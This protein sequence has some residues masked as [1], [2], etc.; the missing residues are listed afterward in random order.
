MEG[1]LKC[2]KLNSMSYRETSLV[3]KFRRWLMLLATSNHLFVYDRDYQQLDKIRLGHVLGMGQSANRTE[4]MMFAE[5]QVSCY[6]CTMLGLNLTD[7]HDVKFNSNNPE[8][9]II[10]VIQ[11]GARSDRYMV[12]LTER[13]EKSERLVVEEYTRGH[14]QLEKYEIS[15]VQEH[16][17]FTKSRVYALPDDEYL[18]SLKGEII[19]LKKKQK[20]FMVLDNVS[21]TSSSDFLLMSGDSLLY[22]E[23][24]TVFGYH[25][26][27]EREKLQLTMV[28]SFADSK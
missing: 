2:E 22:I 20:T 15:E 21:S 6:E 3:V 14:E 1:S 5:R 12:F 28:D 17:L 8:P 19:A 27:V 25:A 7:R 9:H 10:D 11:S 18:L 26:K 13:T 4:L 24:S 23:D 16:G